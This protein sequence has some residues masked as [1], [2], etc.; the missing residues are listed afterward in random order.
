MLQNY[1]DSTAQVPTKGKELEKM[2]A[3]ARRERASGGLRFDVFAETK[4]S[5]SQFDPNMNKILMTIDTFLGLTEA[6]MN[7]NMLK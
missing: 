7:F 3:A 5:R 6:K 2:K 4:M 1:R